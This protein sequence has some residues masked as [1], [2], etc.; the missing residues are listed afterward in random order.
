MNPSERY[1]RK[2]AKPEFLRGVSKIL[3]SNHRI[4]NLVFLTTVLMLTIL[5]SG[6]G[7]SQTKK[8]D[9]ST[10]VPTELTER[11]KRLFHRWVLKKLLFLISI[12]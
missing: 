5:F 12:Y 11:E 2:A 10:I 3:L 6:Y 7:G 8:V 1:R 4:A 9:T